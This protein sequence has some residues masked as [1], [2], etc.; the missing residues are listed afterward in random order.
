MLFLFSIK[1]W[2]QAILQENENPSFQTNAIYQS[3]HLVYINKY[4][5]DA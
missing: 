3:G 2:K 1:T 5:R 4:L